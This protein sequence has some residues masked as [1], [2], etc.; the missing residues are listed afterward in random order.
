MRV[1]GLDPATFSCSTAP[2]FGP[3]VEYRFLLVQ[4]KAPK[5]HTWTPPACQAFNSRPRYHGHGTRSPIS[6]S[7]TVGQYIK[8][9]PRRGIGVK[10]QYRSLNHPPH[11]KNL[12]VWEHRAVDVTS[13]AMGHQG[14]VS[15]FP[16]TQRGT[17][18]FRTPAPGI[19]PGG[20][21]TFLLVQESKQR[22]T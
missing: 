22:S 14:Q 3:A 5:K 7:P 13:C 12:D 10:S 16:S 20:R 9:R 18:V 2:G 11:A 1:Y 4:R 8:V 15:H 6:H 19:R 17:P 21:L